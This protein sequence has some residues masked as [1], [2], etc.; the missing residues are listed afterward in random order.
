VP[1][2]RNLFAAP[3]IKGAREDLKVSEAQAATG[4][5]LTAGI[6]L[7]DI[8][9]GGTIAGRVSDEAVL[10][11]RIDGELYAVSGT[12]THYGGHLSDGLADGR[13]VRCPLHHAC[14][15]L[16][17]GAALRGPALDPLDRWQVDVDSDKAYVS[18]KLKARPE[19]GEDTGADARRIV[20]IGGGAAGL[21]CANELRRLGFSGSI[22]MLSADSD[23]PC[24]RPNLSKDYLAGTAPEEW[25]PLR[26]ADWYSDNNIELRLSTPVTRI[27]PEARTVHCASGE[28]I[29]F[30]KLLI[31]TGSEPNRLMTPGFDGEKVFTLRSIADARAIAA[32]A[33]PG[34]RAVVIG[35]SFIAMEAAAALRARGAEVDV[36]A[37]EHVP[38]DRV[39]GI[40]LGEYITGIHQR[41]G[42]RFHLGCVASGYDGRTVT[43][44]NGEQIEADFVV[45]GIG[46]QPRTDLARSAGA[47]VD[48]GILVDAFLET[49]VP[50]IYAAGDIASYPDAATGERV[51]IEHWVVAERQG[52]VAAA[53]MVGSRRP[54]QSVP[55]FWTEQF[56][57]AIRYVG[58]G[59]G[60]DKVL[61]DGDVEGGS[62]TIRYFRDDVHCAS[63]SVGRDKDN[64]EDELTL[65]NCINASAGRV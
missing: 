8:T 2:A 5:D 59:A 42:V 57:T 44:A 12:C 16:K 30:D 64:L 36:V 27:D 54:Y 24:D 58:R 26:P 9:E 14:F 61:V 65:E 20:I 31:A 38:F 45:V 53:N 29:H 49:S 13:T 39:F 41:N 33:T 48:N 56:G 3:S 6:P 15:D 52:Q 21:A 17:T 34:S 23:P 40:A 35:A 62:F 18:Y 4:P 32:Q 28:N 7:S 47:E 11:S 50:G 25:L 60:W 1:A 19:S 46:V 10:L 22:I 55:F 43:I 63:A 37:V 51:R